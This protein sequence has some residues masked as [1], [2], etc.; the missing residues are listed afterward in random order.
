MSMRIWLPGVLSLILV[1]LM[2]LMVTHLTS[3]ERSTSP[4]PASPAAIDEPPRLAHTVVPSSFSRAI[5]PVPPA[6]TLLSGADSPDVP[7]GEGEARAVAA[8][9]Q[10]SERD[11][12]L[13]R[14][15]ASG[16]DARRLTAKASPLRATWETMANRSGIE[17]DVSPWEC[18]RGGCF[19]TVVH[20]DPQ[21]VEGLSSQILGSQDLASWSGPQTRSAPIPRT[22][23]TAEV[24]WFLLSPAEGS[25]NGGGGSP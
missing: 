16:P 2:G 15:R 13:A 7:A 4:R 25:P 20:R 9:P 5:S 11:Q 22:D 3:R 14:L 17:V 21:S 18:Y 24:T 1:G 19:T 6:P 12:Q 23:G 8:S 10:A